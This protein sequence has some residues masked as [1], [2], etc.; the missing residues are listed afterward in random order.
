L[1]RRYSR[2]EAD[3]VFGVEDFDDAEE[4]FFDAPSI[5]YNALQNLQNLH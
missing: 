5:G 2:V 1:S 3:E 4:G